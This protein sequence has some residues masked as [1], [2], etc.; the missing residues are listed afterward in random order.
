[1]FTL[2]I[3]AYVVYA[4][5]SIPYFVWV[6]GHHGGGGVALLGLV[7]HVFALTVLGLYLSSLGIFSLWWVLLIPEAAGLIA[8][9]VMGLVD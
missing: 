4:L 8:G 5:L 3:V 1:M 7:G 2:L 6:G 9:L